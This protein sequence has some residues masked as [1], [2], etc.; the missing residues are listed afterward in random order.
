MPTMEHLKIASAVLQLVERI[1][2]ASGEVM[3]GRTNM[4]QFVAKTPIVFIVNLQKRM[5][6]QKLLK[7]QATNFIITAPILEMQHVE[8]DNILVPLL[9]RKKLK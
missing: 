3:F 2:C 4:I 6:A 5:F 1:L 7:N 9:K 8:V